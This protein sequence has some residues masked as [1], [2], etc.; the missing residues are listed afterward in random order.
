MSDNLLPPQPKFPRWT[1]AAALLS[2]AAIVGAGPT[3]AFDDSLFA[4]GG[5]LLAVCG[6][7]LWFVFDPNTSTHDIDEL[8]ADEDVQ[9]FLGRQA[10]GA[11][12]PTE[13]ELTQDIARLRDINSRLLDACA[14]HIDGQRT[15]MRQFA[16]PGVLGTAA[17]ATADWLTLLAF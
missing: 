11:R 13:A 9:A 6:A 10:S 4:R 1:V 12:S 8:I 2:L 16:I 3:V 14:V 17:A 7:L 15:M 5:G